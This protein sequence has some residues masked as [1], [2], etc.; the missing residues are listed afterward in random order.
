MKFI[1]HSDTA[2]HKSST[3]H[4][5][6]EKRAMISLAETFA[7]KASEYNVKFKFKGKYHSGLEHT[8]LWVA[9]AENAH[10]IQDLMV[11]TEVSRSML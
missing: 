9:D 4:K 6:I 8:F 11:D 10:S 2:D 3:K 1:F 7:D 5:V